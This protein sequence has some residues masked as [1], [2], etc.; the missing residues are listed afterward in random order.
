M[1]AFIV[2]ENATLS[3]PARA[4]IEKPA[5]KQLRIIKKVKK[6]FAC[7]VM[8]VLSFEQALCNQ[9]NIF[10]RKVIYFPIKKSNNEK[11]HITS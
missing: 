8:F 11:I 10:V 6:I 9:L 1:S 4:V 3:S 2:N 5:V 7:F